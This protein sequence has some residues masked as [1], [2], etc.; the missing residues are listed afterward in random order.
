MHLHDD[1][2]KSKYVGENYPGNRINL[3]GV[4]DAAMDYG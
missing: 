3:T 2:F 4:N 1:D